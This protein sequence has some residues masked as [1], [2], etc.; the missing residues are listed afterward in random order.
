VAEIF[1]LEH[2]TDH[3]IFGHKDQKVQGHEIARPNGI[4]ES[5]T[6]CYWHDD[7][8]WVCGVTMGMF[9]CSC[10]AKRILGF[11]P[12]DAIRKRGLCCHPVSVRPSVCPSVTLVH[13]IQTA[14]DIIKLLSGPV[15]QSF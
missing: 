4:S 12:R 3:S 5:A 13:C 7:N 15:A 14:E 11:L 6:H 9:L 10:T 2:L 8:D 1:S